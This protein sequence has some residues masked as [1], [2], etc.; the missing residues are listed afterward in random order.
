MDTDD[1][2]YVSLAT[3]LEFGTELGALDGLRFRPHVTVSVTQYL[4][5]SS[6]SLTV[7][8]ADAGAALDGLNAG[9]DIATKFFDLSCG[10]DDF[11]WDHVVLPAGAFTRSSSVGT[12]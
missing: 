3:A 10:I 1:E 9:T 11:A 7:K 8:F 6:S 5:N 2:T 12:I 4:N